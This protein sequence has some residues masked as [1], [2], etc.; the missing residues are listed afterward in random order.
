MKSYENLNGRVLRQIIKYHLIKY[1]QFIILYIFKAIPHNKIY[2]A[3]Y[4]LVL[5]ESFMKFLLPK[6]T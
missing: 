1:H 4:S 5:H 6:I 3:H 2:F